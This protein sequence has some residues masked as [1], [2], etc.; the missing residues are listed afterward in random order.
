M[1][2][3]WMRAGLVAALGLLIVAA[4]P[5]ADD[6][7]KDRR[8]RELWQLMTDRKFA[9]FAAAGDDKMRAVL[10]A[11]ACKG[12]YERLEFQ[13]GRYQAIE[14]SQVRASAPWHAVSL[15]CRHE[16]GEAV[17]RLVLDS[18]DRL[19]GLWLD[20]IEPRDDPN[21]PVAPYVDKQAFSEREVVASR[22]SAGLELKGTLTLPKRDGPLPGVVLVHG[23]GPHDRDETIG[24]NKPFRDLA[25]GLATRGVAVLRYEKRTK[26]Y[27]NF[28]QADEWTLD[29]ET[30]DDALAAVRALREAP[31]VDARRVFVVGH[32]LGAMAAPLI[33][34]R[35]GKLAGIALL[36]GSPRSIVDLLE[37]QVTYIA[38]FDGVVTDEEREQ[39]DAIR[40]LVAAVRSG[41]LAAA[42]A[43][44]GLS[45]R[46][47]AR[48]HALD[49]MGAARAL[50]LP[51]LICH[52]GRD[53]QVS[54]QD[55]EL[56]R[57][58][59][60]GRDNVTF[61]LFEALNHLFMEGRGLSSPEEYGRAGHV[62]GAL[63]E[64]LAGWITAQAPAEP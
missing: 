32:S 62:S 46:Y 42:P 55:F 3:G 34:R 4:A 12:L 36:A 37:E 31:E 63:I 15:T 26:A 14:R 21:A 23:S 25:W 30:V 44:A 19:T 39:L 48:M 58:G 11:D 51:V 16:R 20:R 7:A 18:E 64:R 56:W 5:T 47:L 38:N 17:I 50:K 6:A 60:A 27:P 8:A 24:P 1:S 9:A 53:Y 54:K 35:D 10:T 2:G 45:A 41:D 40:A 28:K 57:E 52:G 49:V 13:L 61:E 43:D 22:A 59:L 29:D 33:A